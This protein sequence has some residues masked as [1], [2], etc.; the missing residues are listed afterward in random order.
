MALAEGA[1][2]RPKVAATARAAAPLVRAFLIENMVASIERA[3]IF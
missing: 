1:V 3:T 2:D